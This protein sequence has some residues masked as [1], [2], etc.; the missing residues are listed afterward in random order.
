MALGGQVDGK[1]KP[2]LC[3]YARGLVVASAEANNRLERVLRVLR[4]STP[5]PEGRPD[6]P[7]DDTPLGDLGRAGD[8]LEQLHRQ[9]G[10]LE[11]LI[12]HNRLDSPEAPRVVGG[13]G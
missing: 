9:L 1:G 8:Q 6:N 12:G 11:E 2:N 5:M 10:M 3:G 7:G 4:G 13:R